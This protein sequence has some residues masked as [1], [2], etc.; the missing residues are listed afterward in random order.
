M[1]PRPAA[2]SLLVRVALAA[3]IAISAW[4]AFNRASAPLLTDD[5][6]SL[7]TVALPA[8]GMVR[9]LAADVHPPLYFLLLAPWTRAF[10]DSE[11]ALRLLSILFYFLSI[12]AMYRLCR[13][14][15]DRDGAVL[16]TAIYAFTPLV[17]LGA[18]LVRMYSLL[19][20]LAIVSTHFWLGISTG[21][22]ARVLD[23]TLW[24]IANIL[25]TFCHLWFFCLLLGQ[26]L[27]SLVLHRARWR[28]LLAGFVLSVTPYALVWLPSL[29]AQLHGSNEAAAWL[30]KPDLAL[31]QEILVMQ[32]GLMALVLPVVLF[33]AWEERQWD[34][35][36][37][38]WSV[39]LLAFTL[40]PP[41][42]L[43]FI[44]PF[45]H[46]RFTIVATHI[47]ALILGLMASRFFDGRLTVVLALLAVG[48]SIAMRPGPASC[49]SRSLAAILVDTLHDNDVV[50]YSSLSRPPVD[51]YLDRI[52][53]SRPWLETSFPPEIDTHPG[54]E[55]SLAVSAARR[56]EL[57]T[58]AEQLANQ[59]AT[60]RGATVY[61]LHG[62]RPMTDRTLL[63]ALERR[64][65]KVQPPFACA[66]GG[67][68][69]T[70]VTAFRVPAAR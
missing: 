54:Y 34:F 66:G 28:P 5:I 8:F 69:F 29:L 33:R 50:I 10:G 30:T 43:S 6:W 16:S 61:V 7:R 36:I 25:G 20:L 15:Q 22:P 17:V 4:L 3:V 1:T 45:F 32:F 63:D 12:L 60:R 52:K 18:N 56:T 47:L 70:E 62:V 42:L 35:G 14:F 39:L 38:R 31:L 44:K 51:H 41:L 19:S 27:T 23:W 48:F 24:L 13:R 53:P 9:A 57:R 67:A 21:K 46:I 64:F 2:S 65:K 68:Y 59:I 37:P 40:L 49:N 55:G 11:V 26:G 58:V